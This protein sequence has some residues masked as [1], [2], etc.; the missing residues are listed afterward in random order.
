MNIKLVLVGICFLVA[1]ISGFFLVD[2]ETTERNL[3]ETP[4]P[5][6][7][8]SIEK[9]VKDSSKIYTNKKVKIS[10]KPKEEKRIKTQEYSES[11]DE[12][13]PVER[14]TE[15]ER[16]E[17]LNDLYFKASYKQLKDQHKVLFRRLNLSEE[18]EYK[19]AKILHEIRALKNLRVGSL[20]PPGITDE[21]EREQ[22]IT[23]LQSE[24]GNMSKS[25]DLDMEEL[26]GE[27]HSK[28]EQYEAF[29]KEYWQ[30][31]RVESIGTLNEHDLIF[32]DVEQD[33]LA[34][35][36]HD[37][38]KEF[39]T[40]KRGWERAIRESKESAYEFLDDMKELNESLIADAPA[41]QTQKQALKII[42]K[43]QFD[44]FQRMVHRIYPS[45]K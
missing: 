38:Y 15:T 7:L 33:E 28:Y 30:L 17:T 6:K 14:L 12:E 1:G 22:E 25:L 44:H 45:K 41:N 19:L 13:E 20:L 39:N 27:D 21:N 37:S 26:L 43:G 34:Q 16:S 2:N 5:K 32:N 18:D 36:M 42:Y 10:E 9:T 40:D 29:Q 3:S 35:Y 24:I 11:L 4:L 31:S 8:K 23:R